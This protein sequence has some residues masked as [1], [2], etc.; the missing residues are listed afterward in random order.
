MSKHTPALWQPF[1]SKDH[2]GTY[3]VEIVGLGGR[4]VCKLY[5]AGETM[6]DNARLIAAAPMLL[7][8]AK[9][10]IALL[11]DAHD[12]GLSISEVEPVWNT[13][14]NAIREAEGANELDPRD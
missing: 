4:G 12:K 2:N 8:A 9:L 1:H 10:A 3:M 7:N 13:L 6:L 5:G 11:V 14:D